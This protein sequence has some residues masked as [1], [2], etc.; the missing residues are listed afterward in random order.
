M[1]QLMKHGWNEADV[2]YW[3]EKGWT[4]KKRPWRS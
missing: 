3:Q 4:G 2:R 1:R